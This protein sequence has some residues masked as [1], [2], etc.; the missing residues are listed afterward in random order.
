MTE[1]CSEPC[2]EPNTQPYVGSEVGQLRRVLLHRPGRELGRLTPANK[3][4]LLFDEMPWLPRAQEEHDHFAATL[5]DLGVEVLYLTDVLAET[6]AVPAARTF[7]L[8]R[9]VTPHLVGPGAVDPLRA[10]LDALSPADLTDAIIGGLDV[11]EAVDRSG[12][13]ARSL[14]VAA[15][16]PE[17]LLL[18]ALPNHLF[19]RDTSCWIY[20]GVSVNTMTLP[21]RQR[22]ALNLEAVYRWHP[23]LS[24][25]EFASWNEPSAPSNP[26][27]EGGDVHVLGRGAVLVGLSE[28]TRPQAVELLAQRLFAAGAARR[29]VAVAM[30]KARAVMHLDTVMA[31]V[32][33]RSFTKYAGL[34]DLPTFTLQP[35]DGPTGLQVTAH[36]AEQMH[37]AI[38]EAMGLDTIRT[39]TPPQSAG[40]AAREQWDDGC[41]VL[42]VRPGVVI[43]YER[44][45]A[46]IDHLRAQGVEVHTIDGSELGRGR[47]GPRCMSCPI[48][49]EDI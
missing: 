43:G 36:P 46:S 40:M 28:R 9:L 22:E 19:T 25:G 16:A 11:Q 3:D 23:V 15:A 20:G 6:L 30:P 48:E 47:G 17:D 29:V 34:G 7:L 4:G 24:R 5:R 35:G 44:N 27:L 45:T 37:H 1:P 49:R 41:N 8:D 39:F 26:S 14:T 31:M 2:S 12:A 38:A 10:L 13:F 42:T 33:E 18:P 32:D 21:A